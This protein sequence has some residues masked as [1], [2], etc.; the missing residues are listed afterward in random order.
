[1]KTSTSLT[2]Q[3]STLDK[4]DQTI[5]TKSADG[6]TVTDIL[7]SG[8]NVTLSE[9]ANQFPTTGGNTLTI[10][11]DS[12]IADV[13]NFNA[14]GVVIVARQIDIS[15]LNFNGNVQSWPIPVPAANAIAPAVLEC[16]IMNSVSNNSL[17]PLT[18]IT[19]QTTGTTPTPFFT[20]PTNN[21]TGVL[22]IGEFNVNP[23]GTTKVIPTNQFSDL[24][25]R[26]YALN[27]F[28]A[29]FSYATTLIN[30]G[31]SG[32][33]K[34]AFSILNWICKSIGSCGT[35]PSTHAELYSQASSLLISL[36][37]PEN[38][39]YLGV[40]SSNF[41]GSQITNLITVLQSYN[42]NLTTLNQQS[43]TQ[44][45]IDTISKAVIASANAEAAPTTTEFNQV[46]NSINSLY[47]NI[48]DLTQNIN[49][50]ITVVNTKSQLLFGAIKQA[51]IEKFLTDSI[52]TVTDFIGAGINITSAVA[53]DG[54]GAGDAFSS[55]VEAFTQSYETIKSITAN[56]NQGNLVTAAQTLMQTN[57][58]LFKSVFTSQQ[59]WYQINNPSLSSSKISFN[60]VPVNMDPN[61]AWDN[62]MTEVNS[63]LSSLSSSLSDGGLSSAQE[64]SNDYLASLQEFANYGK[65]LN[66]QIIAY[67]NQLCK[68]VVLTTKLS[69]INNIANI[70]NSLNTAAE[71]EQEKLTS[72]Q[73]LIQNRIDTTMRSLFMAW[74][75]YRSAYLY[76]NLSE[77]S[78]TISMDSSIGD[79]TSAFTSIQSWVAGMPINGKGTTVLPSKNSTITLTV[80]VVNTTTNT[81]PNA[82]INAAVAYMTPANSTS[83]TTIS[84]SIQ[85]I[86]NQFSSQIG[87]GDVAIW[88]TNG[89]FIINGIKANTAGYVPMTVST[90][91]Q[92][93]NG[94]EDNLLNFL[95]NSISGHFS[96]KPSNNGGTPTIN[97][98][99]VI[100]TEAYML[101]TPYTIWSFQ[102]DSGCD[103]SSVNDIT[104]TLTVNMQFES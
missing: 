92:Y 93:V 56:Y 36:N 88:I 26:P 34:T 73:G 75:N 54:D 24:V 87:S 39:H 101:P 72:L 100:S 77:P 19:S 18:F 15:S 83:P 61:L 62:F 59:L 9:L 6:K 98:P 86:L 67:S 32:S 64:Q 63:V 79:L 104:I 16:L 66:S 102:L 40:L 58:S 52:K 71:T 69:A 84:V 53:K 91:G 95:S 74:T 70:W 22:T 13:P 68:G 37:V 85:K 65:A 46:K 76:N 43:D 57:E 47:T 7:F 11:A 14:L 2:A 96:Y 17:V 94:Y 27:T 44:G 28:Y 20:A 99:W 3:T 81:T 29:S 82:L 1:M 35:I 33:L 8:L 49:L 12:I 38:Y 55:T 42:T 25:S 80:P 90:S 48:H 23:D 45:I 30:A 5:I 97:V 4:Y 41:Y 60:P 31:D 10:Y 89:Q 103:V 78:E 50:Q 21:N 51:Q